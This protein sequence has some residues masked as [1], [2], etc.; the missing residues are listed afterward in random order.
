M[1]ADTATTLVRLRPIVHASPLPT[2]IHVRG[3]SSSFTVEGGAGLWNLWRVLERRLVDGVPGHQLVPL[4]RRPEVARAAEL[5]ITQLRAHDMLVE[6]PAGWGES[7]PDLA[8]WLESVAPDPA[9]ALWRLRAATVRVAGPDT[10]LESACRT[11]AAAGVTVLVAD[12]PAGMLHAVAGERAVAA[13]CDEE[14]GFVVPVGAAGDVCRTAAAVAARLGLAPDPSPAAAPYALAALV[15]AAAAHRLVSAV[16]G[17]EDPGRLDAVLTAGGPPPDDYPAVLVARLDPLSASYHPWL[18]AADRAASPVGT[19]DDALRGLDAL[20]DPDL[21]AVPTPV[22]GDLPQL[23]ACLARAGA[24]LG[25]GVSADA[26]RLAAALAAAERTLGAGVSVGVNERHARGATLRRLARA[27][28]PAGEPVADAEW[29]RSPIARRWWKTLTL[30]LGVDAR[31][32]VRRL[33]GGAACAVVTEEDAELAWAIEATAADA[34]AFALLG[35]AGVVQARRAGV[36]AVAGLLTGAAPAWRPAGGDTTPWTD[37]AWYWP[38]D[39]GDAEDRLQATL[40]DVALGP[41]RPV[42]V[43]AA[44]ELVRSLAAVG[45]HALGFDA[46]GFDGFGPA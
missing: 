40:V 7:D 20:T 9:T 12:G 5:I 4:A 37:D 39:V 14:T 27:V 46:V 15:G 6:V 21:G 22:L 28:A 2:G 1:T 44:P 41:L 35:A 29:D 38:A 26:A 24:A 3:W 36:A 25:V 16:A 19:I 17:L 31:I 23:P 13:R 8:A 33:P 34:V 10:L 45:F 42:P 18:P 43:G 32:D 11:L 30:R